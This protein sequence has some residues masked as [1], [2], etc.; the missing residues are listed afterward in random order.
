MHK[1]ELSCFM[2][3]KQGLSCFFMPA[4]LAPRR[5]PLTRF[6][7]SI[8]QV[9]GRMLSLQ[10]LGGLS[11]SPSNQPPPAQAATHPVPDLGCLGVNRNLHGSQ[12]THFLLQEMARLLIMFRL[13]YFTCVP[14]SVLLVATWKRLRGRG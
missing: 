9:R 2:T 1:K 8:A 14:D 5:L 3:H 7:H 13:L 4:L 6:S 10:L 12:N 11:F